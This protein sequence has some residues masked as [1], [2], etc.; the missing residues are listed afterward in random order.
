M[1][2][3]IKPY[4]L[5]Q[6]DWNSDDFY[7]L[8]RYLHRLIL[9]ADKKQDEITHLDIQK[10]SEKTKVLLYCIINY[11]H[12]EKMF[13]LSNLHELENCKPLSEPLV[14]CEHG[15]KEENVY[16]KMNVMF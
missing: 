2:N 9:H 15:M 11:Y 12:L 4:Y 5:D 3:A 6:N 13:E 7:S 8:H 10:M 14:L 16:Y 1:K